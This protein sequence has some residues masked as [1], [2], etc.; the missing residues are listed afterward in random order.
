MLCD[1][2]LLPLRFFVNNLVEFR[3][4]ACLIGHDAGIGRNQRP[5]FNLCFGCQTVNFDIQFVAFDG[6]E[7]VRIFAVQPRAHPFGRFARQFDCGMI[8]F[9]IQTECRAEVLPVQPHRVGITPHHIRDG[10]AE[11]IA[12]LPFAHRRHNQSQLDFGRRLFVEI[13]SI[14]QPCGDGRRARNPERGQLRIVTIFVAR[15][16]PDRN[17]FNGRGRPEVLIVQSDRTVQIPIRTVRCFDRPG[18][19]YAHTAVRFDD[20]F[21]FQAFQPNIALVRSFASDQ[22][23]RSGN[24]Y[25]DQQKRR[26]D[27]FIH[28]AQN[29][30]LG[31]SL[32]SS[33]ASK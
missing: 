16:V 4:F 9:D 23:K 32:V 26:Y 24:Q 7:A 2:L 1:P 28:T 5:H 10:I 15:F 17:I 14:L 21:D 30:T 20:G 11:G 3:Y 31:A 19:G 29:C 25:G 13:P 27:F 18:F 33:P 12:P 6:Q 8:R 22:R